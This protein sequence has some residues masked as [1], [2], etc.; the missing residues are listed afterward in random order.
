MIEK[1][2]VFEPSYAM[3]ETVLYYNLAESMLSPIG[4]W[5]YQK[6]KYGNLK[7]G[8][9]SF[10]L[11]LFLFTQV[12]HE[13]PRTILYNLTFYALDTFIPSVTIYAYLKDFFELICLTV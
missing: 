1:S 4:L 8:F 6:R 11:F 13:M 3:V 10:N 12:V 9:V 5:P 7:N 2:V